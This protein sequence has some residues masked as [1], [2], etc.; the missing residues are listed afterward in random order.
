MIPILKAFTITKWHKQKKLI[1]LSFEA[2]LHSIL[3][4]LNTIS[5]FVISNHIKKKQTIQNTEMLLSCTRD[6]NTQ[7][8]HDKTTVLPIFIY[9]KLYAI[10]LK[11]LNQT[12]TH[13][14]CIIMH[15]QICPKI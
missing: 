1:I 3:E 12:Q 7:H 8:L 5:C 4:Y 14:S 13:L 10:Q 6:T 15:I 9:F 11:Q 2:I